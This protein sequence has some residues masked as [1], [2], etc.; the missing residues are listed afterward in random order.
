MDAVD[1][2]T[3][4]LADQAYAAILD[5][6]VTVDLAPGASFSEAE[7]REALD[8]GKTPIREALT[9]LRFEGFVLVQPRSGYH[10]ADVT[11]QDAK[12][13]C[14]FRALIEGATSHSAA[15]YG[16]RSA[17]YLR[18]VDPGNAPDAAGLPTREALNLDSVFHVE[19]ARIAENARATEALERLLL[20]FTRLCHLSLAL[21]PRAIFPVHD[22]ADLIDAIANGDGSQA[23]A[24]A[25]GEV[26]NFQSLILEAL[27]SSESVTHAQ[28]ALRPRTQNQFY[29][30]IPNEP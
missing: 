28:V 30:D 26:Q 22:H 11:L 8:L 23:R 10:V 16:P 18:S 13:V 4:T 27:M 20:H 1:R 9:R 21:D 17:S 3:G 5:R 14:A 29:L 7:L 2:T 12:D 24:L 19:L 15:D 6:I 25:V